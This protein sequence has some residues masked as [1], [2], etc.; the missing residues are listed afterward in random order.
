MTFG[1]G[2]RRPFDEAVALEQGQ[3]LVHDERRV[4][5]VACCV[6]RTNEALLCGFFL[7]DRRSTCSSRAAPCVIRHPKQCR[8]LSL[9]SVPSFFA[10]VVFR[11]VLDIA[12]VAHI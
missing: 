3:Q 9:V 11:I 10:M 12:H 8:G 5:Q 1:E 6:R 2:C 4:F 7:D